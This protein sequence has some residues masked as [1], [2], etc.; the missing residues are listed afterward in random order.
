MDNSL[1]HIGLEEKIGTEELCRWI[2]CARK[3]MEMQN[4]GLLEILCKFL[5]F[6]DRE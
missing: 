2:W 6:L 3:G 5:S 4:K 1:W